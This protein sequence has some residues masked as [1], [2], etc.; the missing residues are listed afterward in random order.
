MPPPDSCQRCGVCCF[1]TL[2]T[3]VRLSGYDWSRLG[4]EADRLAHFIGHRAFMRLDDGHCA[5]L[6]IRR[7]PEGGPEFFCAVYDRRPQV[8]RD[9]AR[10][11]PE[12]RGELATKG[13]RVAARFPLEV[14][15]RTA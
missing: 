13:S 15:L 6:Q 1:S 10:G 5:A 11:S 7:A 4:P 9:L 14:P 12:C 8:C 2:E 3:Y